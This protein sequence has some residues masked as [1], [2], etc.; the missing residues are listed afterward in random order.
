LLS[1][2]LATSEACPFDLLQLHH[3]DPAVEEWGDEVMVTVVSLDVKR[4]N[5][6]TIMQIPKGDEAWSPP[7]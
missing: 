5:R 6:L 1:S 2:I 7:S 3:W 4:L